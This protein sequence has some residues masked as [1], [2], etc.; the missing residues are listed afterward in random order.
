M[1]EKRPPAVDDLQISVVP[2]ENQQIII[3][4]LVVD[5]FTEDEQRDFQATPFIHHYNILVHANDIAERL[6][7]I[8][9][10]ATEFW[11]KEHLISQF[12]SDLYHSQAI[13]NNFLKTID[14]EKQRE[15]AMRTFKQELVLDFLHIP[16]PD[17][18]DE[19]DVELISHLWAIS[20]VLLWTAKSRLLTCSSSIVA[21]AHWSQ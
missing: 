20:I 12:K 10:C 3:R 8:H 19:L 5:D 14:D 7:Y 11:T 16:D 9:K 4:P 13:T 17:Y 1:I 21:C 18:V 6:F 15:K 2:F